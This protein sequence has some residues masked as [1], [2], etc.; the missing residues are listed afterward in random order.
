M[1]FMVLISSTTFSPNTSYRNTPSA[2]PFM[3]RSLQITGTSACSRKPIFNRIFWIYRWY[4]EPTSNVRCNAPETGEIE[5]SRGAF[6]RSYT[7]DR[8]HALLRLLGW[9]TPFARISGAMHKLYRSKN[10]P[11]K[12]L[13]SKSSSASS[14]R[15]HARRIPIT[16]KAPTDISSFSRALSIAF[17]TFWISVSVSFRSNRAILVLRVRLSS[18]ITY[19]RFV[20][21]ARFERATLRL[22]IWCSI[23]LSYGT[24][25]G[26]GH[27]PTS[28]RTP[29]PY[30]QMLTPYPRN[31]Y[32][33]NFSDFQITLL[34]VF[35]MVAFLITRPSEIANVE[36]SSRMTKCL[37]ILSG[38]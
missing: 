22:E 38:G 2:L 3:K 7:N 31:K 34:A 23:Q 25:R 11:K 24:D 30:E 18:A 12:S 10:A 37:N 14:I 17:V 27:N 6:W 28:N 26:G 13:R 16:E 1:S 5:A 29:N 8:G 19:Y 33:D 35:F 20:I 21:P 4:H 15:L 32:K 36:R 9:N